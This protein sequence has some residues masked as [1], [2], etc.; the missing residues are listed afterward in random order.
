MKSPSIHIYD[1]DLAT[2]QSLF[3]DWGQPAYR[4]RQL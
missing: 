2:L 1:L 3:K 4:A